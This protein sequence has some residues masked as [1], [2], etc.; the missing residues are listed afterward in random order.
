MSNKT[1]INK[2]DCGTSGKKLLI[3]ISLSYNKITWFYLMFRQA[4]SGIIRIYIKD[5]LRGKK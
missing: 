5:F 2:V 1:S 4:G 3:V